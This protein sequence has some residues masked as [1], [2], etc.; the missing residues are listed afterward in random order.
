[1]DAKFG[2]AEWQTAMTARI[3]SKLDAGQELD[4][5]EKAFL[6]TQ[7]EHNTRLFE[8]D[9]EQTVKKGSVFEEQSSPAQKDVEQR[10]RRHEGLYGSEE[11]Q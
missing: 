5:S 10:R 1:M 6:E 4:G 9:G 8:G 11:V 7:I 3:Q 2:S